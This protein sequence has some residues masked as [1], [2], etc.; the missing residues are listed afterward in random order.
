M[1]WGVIVVCNR[2]AIEF[3]WL[4]WNLLRKN[5][6]LTIKKLVH[7]MKCW[8]KLLLLIPLTVID[9][10]YLF[11]ISMIVFVCCCVVFLFPFSFS[12]EM[13]EWKL[14]IF[15]SITILY[16]QFWVISHYINWEIINF[17]VAN[18]MYSCYFRFKFNILNQILILVDCT[19]I[20]DFVYHVKLK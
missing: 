2:A 1:C 8:N 16:K 19:C 15:I 14:I 13:F 17:L 18:K 5:W 7:F 10:W 4:L 9:I 20:L 3:I 6:I 12:S 11:I